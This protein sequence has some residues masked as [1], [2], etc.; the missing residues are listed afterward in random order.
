MPRSTSCGA[1]GDAILAFTP[2]SEADITAR[3]THTRTSVTVTQGL[4]ALAGKDDV[5]DA[6][7]SLQQARLTP[8]SRAVGLA[9]EKA[10]GTNVMFSALKVAAPGRADGRTRHPGCGAG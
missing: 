6:L 8:T 1:A 3:L 10:T 2:L 5:T 9:M 7:R 4:Q